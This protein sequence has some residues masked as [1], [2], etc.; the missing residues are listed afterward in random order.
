MIPQLS[1]TEILLILLLLLLLFGAGKL[2]EV[3][4]A[5]GEGIRNFKKSLSGEEERVKEVKGQEVKEGEKS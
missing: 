5:L 4:R 1:F 3:G 2:P